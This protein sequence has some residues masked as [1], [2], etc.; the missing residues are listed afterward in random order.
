MLDL[1]LR[2]SSLG[3]GRTT[4]ARACLVEAVVEHAHVQRV[5]ST[6]VEATAAR[7]PDQPAQTVL[8]ARKECL[9]R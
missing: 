4:A 6:L 3:I 8:K 9:P 5:D 2:V 1:A 7:Q